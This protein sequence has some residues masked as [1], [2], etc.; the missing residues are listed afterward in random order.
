MAHPGLDV[1]ALPFDGLIAREWLVTNALGGYACST[2]PSLN[3]RKYHGLLVAAMAPPVRRMVL[4]S[5]VEETVYFN[6][7]PFA[8]ACNEYPGTIHPEG[9]RFLRAFSHE[10][11]PRWA[12]QGDGWTL[13]K[14]LHLVRGRNTVVLTYTLLGGDKPIDLELR[15]LLALRGI[16]E[17]TYQWQAPL[18]VE[19]APQ[20]AP[21]ARSQSRGG[22]SRAA[23]VYAAGQCH[24]VPATGRTPEVFF[25]HDGTFEAQPAWYF[26]TIYRREQERGYPGLEDLWMPG[27]VKFKLSPGQTVHFAC[28]ADP[29]TAGDLV[30]TESSAAPAKEPDENFAALARAADQFI[31]TIP[32]APDETDSGTSEPAV[33]VV[34]QYPW[35]PPSVRLALVAFPGLFLATG[36]QAEGRSLLLSYARLLDGGLLP[37]EFPEDGSPPV[38]NGADVSLW[39]VHAAHQYLRHTGDDATV[40][41]ELYDTLAMIVHYYLT[42]TRLGIAAGADGLIST[43]EPGIGTTWM[44][45]GAGGAAVTPRAG[46]PVDLNALWFNALRTVAELSE[47]FDE[48]RWAAE[49]GQLADTVKRSFNELFW[50]ESA[51]CCYDVIT[52]AGPDPAVRPNQ[53]LA[54]SLPFPV[55]DLARHEPVLRKVRDELLTP[56]GVRTLAPSDPNYQPRYAGNVAARDRAHHN[57]SAFP[58]L[59]GALVTTHARV[60]GRGTKARAEAMD[61][62]RGCLDHLRGD[63]LG[64]LCEL[65]DGAPPHSPGGAIAA[66]PAVAEI[67]QA[68]AEHVLDEDGSGTALPAFAPGA[69]PPAPLEAPVLEVFLPPPPVP[70]NEPA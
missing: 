66:A 13:E 31:A 45:A 32:N 11:F 24:R 29:I 67:L 12:Y 51:G 25:G 44:D 41:R 35:S 34:T 47:M 43:S 37:S 28:S 57:G 22:S 3:S 61:V 36:R 21:A 50:N 49:L 14:S 65:F 63:G 4:L 54:A 10:P 52:D 7:W 40:R 53:L 30:P 5:R 27:V 38:Y 8:L 2:I 70:E 16:H 17:L 18:T 68:Y 19:P 39:F 69:A 58:W 42:G 6:G 55:L 48:P 64:Q 60:H 15:P 23:Q 20:P 26:N 1:S 56:L 59:L 9:H 62:L 46:K 33:A